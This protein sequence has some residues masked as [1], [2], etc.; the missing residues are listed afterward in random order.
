MTIR[1]NDPYALFGVMTFRATTLRINY[2]YTLV[3]VMTFRSNVRNALFGVMT[4]RATT[5]RSN[6][7]YTLFGVMTFRSNVPYVL[8]GVMTFRA[9]TLR[10]NDMCPLR[11]SDEQRTIMFMFSP[12]IMIIGPDG[13]CGAELHTRLPD[14]NIYLCCRRD[15]DVYDI[16]N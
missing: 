2:R 8:F 9:T 16:H 15:R 7:R 14:E 12:I 1:N 6:Y 13:W 5:L 10:S 11:Y 3:G 4:F